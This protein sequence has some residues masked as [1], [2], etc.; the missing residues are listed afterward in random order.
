MGGGYRFPLYECMQTRRYLLNARQTT[1]VDIS[2][3]GMEL[4]LKNIWQ[5][6]RVYLVFVQQF[7]PTLAFLCYW[8]N[9]NVINGKM[10]RK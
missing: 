9:F 6:L 2:V 8:A 5:F 7:E 10:L 1:Q 4:F 3:T